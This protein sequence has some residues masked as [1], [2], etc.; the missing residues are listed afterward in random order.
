MVMPPESA[1]KL[2]AGESRSNKSRK[3][4]IH[5]GFADSNFLHTLNYTPIDEFILF[6]REFRHRLFEQYGTMSSTSR[7]CLRVSFN[8]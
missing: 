3:R 8:A 4:P 1:T 2:L 7:V 5:A 6:D